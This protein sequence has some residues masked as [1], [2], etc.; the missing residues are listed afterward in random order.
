LNTCRA[1]STYHSIDYE[2]FLDG[3]AN[4]AK[5]TNCES[6]ARRD[7]TQ[8]GQRIKVK[9]VYLQDRSFGHDHLVLLETTTGKHAQSVF[10]CLADFIVD[11]NF[12]G[13]ATEM[14]VTRLFPIRALTVLGTIT[15][16]EAL[17]TVE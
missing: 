17:A 11:P 5:R 9:I 7:L 4:G 2:L 10:L 13:L 16:L 3:T 1:I 14:F 6:E 15:A 12:T 8:V